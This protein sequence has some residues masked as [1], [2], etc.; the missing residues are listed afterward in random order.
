MQ[1]ELPE[2]NGVLYCT[3]APAALPPVSQRGEVLA[4]RHGLTNAWG[5][6]QSSPA[7][8]LSGSHV[9]L[10]HVPC[11]RKP[12]FMNLKWGESVTMLS[13]VRE[14][15]GQSDQSLIRSTQFV[16]CGNHERGSAACPQRGLAW[17]SNS[18]EGLCMVIGGKHD[19]T[20]YI[21]SFLLR[22]MAP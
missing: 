21:N 22:E 2:P 5:S 9:V 16:L 15:T 19:R 1:L 14:V 11:Y 18:I 4:A 7:A 20:K 6:F 12:S 3:A 13:A 8:L 17:E 10:K